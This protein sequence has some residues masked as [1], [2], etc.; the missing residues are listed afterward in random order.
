MD[1]QSL[2]KIPDQL[3]ELEKLEYIHVSY[4]P[5]LESVSPELS[6]LEKLERN[7]KYIRRISKY[8]I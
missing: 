2:T 1:Y 8:G 6:R 4:N 3:G 7:K 5:L